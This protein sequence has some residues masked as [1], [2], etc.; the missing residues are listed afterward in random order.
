MSVKKISLPCSQELL[1]HCGIISGGNQL[2]EA[3]VAG[4][5]DLIGAFV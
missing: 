4:A 2:A 3:A 5:K 1:L